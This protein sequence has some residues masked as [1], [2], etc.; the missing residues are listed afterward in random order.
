[1]Q[2]HG[3]GEDAFIYIAYSAMVTEANLKQAGEHTHFITR[4]PATSNEH[5]RIIL[6][7]IK[8]GHWEAVGRI[9]QT[10]TTKTPRGLL[11]GA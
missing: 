11:S 7:A 10:P 1:M 3:V 4:L 5:E 2:V 8:A 9:A 6:G